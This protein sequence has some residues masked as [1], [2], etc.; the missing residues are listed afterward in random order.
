METINEF[1]VFFLFFTGTVLI[2]EAVLIFIQMKISNALR[3]SLSL[4]FLSS[5]FFFMSLAGRI[6]NDYSVSFTQLTLASSL[7]VLCI[8]TFLTY[9]IFRLNKSK[10]K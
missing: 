8:S 5:G 4:L 10:Q 1:F 2:F 9:V 6:L 3:L 7:I